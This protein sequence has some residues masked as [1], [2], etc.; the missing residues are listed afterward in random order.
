[1]PGSTVSYASSVGRNSFQLPTEEVGQLQGLSPTHA[2]QS[3]VTQTQDMRSTSTTPLMNL[4]EIRSQSKS[5]YLAKQE[6]VQRVRFAM[7][8][9]TGQNVLGDGK[10]GWRSLMLSFLYNAEPKSF[11]HA[12]KECGVDSEIADRMETAA[13]EAK[14]DFKSVLT[15][16]GD[17]ANTQFS[18]KIRYPFEDKKASNPQAE[19][20]LNS[21]LRTLLPKI[22]ANLSHERIDA[23]LSGEHADSDE[24]VSL[25]HQLGQETVIISDY[26]TVH[27]MAHEGSKLDALLTGQG[28]ED[29]FND[30]VVIRHN[31]G[32]SH[33]TMLVP[34]KPED[35]AKRYEN[36]AFDN[37]PKLGT[38]LKA[39]VQKTPKPDLEPAPLL[40][41]IKLEK[42]SSEET[43][44]A[45]TC[46]PKEVKQTPENTKEKTA[47][48]LVQ[49][50]SGL[51]KKL[52]SDSESTFSSEEKAFMYGFKTMLHKPEEPMRFDPEKGFKST[53]DNVYLKDGGFLVEQSNGQLHKRTDDE[54]MLNAI[55]E[56]L[57]SD[58]A[59]ESP[60][61]DTALKAMDHLM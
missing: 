54:A 18:A 38:E 51:V 60:H 48:K 26:E 19:Q 41:S 34:E 12:L 46:S 4:G 47:E 61:F 58:K 20:D 35:A 55:L 37:F 22:D 49:L 59:H 17:D 1:M 11:A 29:A 8:K 16:S 56:F 13:T 32:A 36:L 40:G 31:P 39:E 10:C 27:A 2:P 28:G 44:V 50:L 52:T 45:K 7:M 30:K 5:T 9:H 21:I 57:T 53:V 25:A 14:K 33:F 6:D 43:M 15:S 42:K 24:L 23:L 3:Q